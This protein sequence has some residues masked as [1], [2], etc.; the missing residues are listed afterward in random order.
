MEVRVLPCA[1]NSLHLSRF[2][3]EP[4]SIPDQVRDR[5]SPENALRVKR[6]QEESLP[7]KQEAGGQ[8]TAP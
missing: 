3:G 2:C 4:V 8:N 1:P 5:L 6:V 7:W